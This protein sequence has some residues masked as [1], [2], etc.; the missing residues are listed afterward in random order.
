MSRL[1]A[2]EI[3]ETDLP[4]PSPEMDQERRV[5]VFDLEESNSFALLDGPEGPYALRLGMT[6]DRR[7]RFELTGRDGSDAAAFTLAMGQLEQAVKDYA[8]L[9]DTYVD[10]VKSLP[11]ARIEAIDTA[12]RDIHSEAARQLRALLAGKADVDEPTSRRLFTL[13]CVMM[14]SE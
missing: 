9:C 4:V 2:I 8:T 5:A 11:P 10:A 12:R 7:A 3:D 14:Q 13:I 6:P 1:Y